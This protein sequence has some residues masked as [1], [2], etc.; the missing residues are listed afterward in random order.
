MQL[1]TQELRAQLPKLYAQENVKDPIVHAK[2]FTSDSSWAWYVTEGEPD[3]DDSRFFGYVVGFENEWGYFVLSE[4]DR[5]A[6]QWAYRS[7][8]IST[9]NDVRSGRS[10]NVRHECG[11]RGS[12]AIAAALCQ[13]RRGGRTGVAS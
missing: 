4:L 7:S 6:A 9:L 2:Y 1:L 13:R 8:G 11:R 3:E 10:T 5:R 12:D